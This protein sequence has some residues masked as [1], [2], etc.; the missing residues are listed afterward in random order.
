MIQVSPPEYKPEPEPEFNQY[1]VNINKSLSDKIQSVSASDDLLNH[2]K[3][4][5]M[6][7][8]VHIHEVYIDNVINKLKKTSSL[9]YDNLSNK[10]IKCARNV[11]FLD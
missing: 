8:F 5:T 9:S 7:N 6:L 3:P 11:N 2:N 10:H 4:D 1:Y